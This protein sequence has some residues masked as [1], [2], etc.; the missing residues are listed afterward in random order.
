[1]QGKSE[2]IVGIFVLA[3]LCVFAY[4]GFQIGAFR[5]DK[6]SYNKYILYF[7]DVSGLSR[8]ADVKIAGVKVGWVE[9]IRIASGAE[10]EAEVEVMIRNEY[11]LYAD[12]YAIVRQQG[13]LGPTYLEIIT[14]DPLLR[15][16]EAGETLSK[17]SVAPVSIDELLQQFKKIAGNVENVTQSFKNTMGGEEGEQQIRTLFDNINR[18]AERMASFSEVLERS[19]VRNEDNINDILSLGKDF[20]RLSDKL[21]NEIFP[22]LKNALDTVATAIDR[23]FG[24]VAKSLEDVSV[25]ARDGL[26]SIGSIAEKIDEG[27]GT[28]GKLINEDDTYRDLKVAVGGLKNYFAKV[29]RLHLVF[30]SH[31]EAMRRP[32]DNYKW[33]DGKG[34]FDVRIHPNEDR[35]YQIQIAGSERGHIDRY[36]VDKSYYDV[37]G[38]PVCVDTLN[39]SDADKTE[40][41]YT[42]NLQI[43]NRN[44]YKFGLQFGKIFKDFLAIRFGLIEGFAGIGMDLDIPFGTDKLRW[45]TSL[46]AYDITGQNHKHDRRPHL[47]WL[48]RIY[49]LRN[50][51]FNFGADDFVSKHNSS[52]FMGAGIRFGDDDFK[53]LLSSLSSFGGSGGTAFNTGTVVA[54]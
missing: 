23:D 31:F 38:R 51:Y 50:I 42:Q 37:E 16:L 22:T 6:S 43:Y 32:G 3:A 17:P 39:L 7:K 8:K 19:F 2:T 24:T 13:L 25:Q 11:K 15:Q 9:G 18:T 45:V 5:F 14:G 29:E 20:R 44:S 54:R 26:K 33:E 49:L 40:L 27:K 53:Y 47:K 41:F 35:F 21:E 28:I 10:M 30:D 52:L 46:E 4:M 36:Q 34:F 48:N 12:A 1:L